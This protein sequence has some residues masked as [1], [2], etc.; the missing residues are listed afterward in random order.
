MPRTPMRTALAVGL[1][2]ALASAGVVAADASSSKVDRQIRIAGLS[3]KTQKSLRHAGVVGPALELAGTPDLA[4][5][6]EAGLSLYHAAWGKGGE[7][8]S[9]V[10]AGVVDGA[11]CDEAMFTPAKPGYA[12]AGA[13]GV[14]KVATTAGG[15]PILTPHTLQLRQ[16]YG[17]A[18]TVVRSARLIGPKSGTTALPLKAGAPGFV[19][20]GSP[21]PPPDGDYVELLNASGKVLQKIQIAP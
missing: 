10:V 2:V 13:F 1:A 17:V 4:G 20:F 8:V 11:D 12:T 6:L 3:K 9:G 16:V 14:T 5:S 18:T 21:S 15:T 7:C 19:V